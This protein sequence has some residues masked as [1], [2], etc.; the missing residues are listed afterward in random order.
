MFMSKHSKKILVGVLVFFSFSLLGLVVSYDSLRLFY[1]TK[2]M[3]YYEVKPEKNIEVEQVVEPLLTKNV[4]A[5]GLSFSFRQNSYDI[6]S[7]F[8]LDGRI[9]FDEDEK[10]SQ[11]YVFIDFMRDFD[12]KFSVYIVSAN[13]NS[14]KDSLISVKEYLFYKDE[15]AAKEKV[16][17]SKASSESDLD[18]VLFND[19]SEEDKGIIESW[20]DST[21]VEYSDPMPF[22]EQVLP[23]RFPPHINQTLPDLGNWFLVVGEG[24]FVPFAHWNV[25]GDSIMPFAVSAQ[26]QQ[27]VFFCNVRFLPYYT[28]VLKVEE[29]DL[30]LTK[31]TLVFNQEKFR[32]FNAWYSIDSMRQMGASEEEIDGTLLFFDNR[33]SPLNI[34]HKDHPLDLLGNQRANLYGQPYDYNN[35][36]YSI[37]EIS[38][39]EWI[40]SY[41]DSNGELAFKYF[42]TT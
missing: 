19:L 7:G 35:L 27:D 24:S 5:S 18:D 16:S 3:N 25:G 13:P 32:N 31:T 6:P 12:E 1:I 10:C 2:T 11:E 8:L 20:R 37:E 15:S 36:T 28:D 40:V 9:R 39:S 22:E 38:N 33:L 26:W 30:G 17:E 21:V 29:N 14:N 23:F 34:P 41:Y 42:W 4:A